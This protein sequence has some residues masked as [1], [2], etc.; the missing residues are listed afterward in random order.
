MND[1]LE[2][3]QLASTIIFS[4]EEDA[5]IWRFSSN[6]VYNSQSLYRIINFRGVIPVHVSAV[7]SLKIPPRVHF[8]LWLL[9]KNKVL[10]RD[11]LSLRRKVEDESCLF[12]NEKESVFHLFFDC[13][14]AKQ[15]WV[16]IS[17]CFGFNVGMNFE[18]IGN[19]WLSRKKFIVHNILTS[20]VLWGLW[21]LR[22]ELCFQNMSWRDIRILL[23]KVAIL[24]Q[25][26]L[27]LCPETSKAEL[28]GLIGKLKL[29]A[30]MPGRLIG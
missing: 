17:E 4:F 16:Y 3:L 21:K 9:A 10:T 1:W 2:V 15:I 25:N 22:N 18:S 28:F 7:W 23:M 6:G 12:C 14:V 30:A 11:N 24:A 5:L 26:W 19:M 20:A 13:V 8:F 27:I 29:M